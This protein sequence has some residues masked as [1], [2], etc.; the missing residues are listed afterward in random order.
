MCLT[1]TSFLD[2]SGLLA[3]YI[4]M[5]HALLVLRLFLPGSAGVASMDTQRNKK[6][7]Q[8]GKRSYNSTNFWRAL[9]TLQSC[10]RTMSG[11]QADMPPVML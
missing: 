7:K 9:E 4:C 10:G 1:G 5:I 2:V 8:S 11:E 3:I 6:K